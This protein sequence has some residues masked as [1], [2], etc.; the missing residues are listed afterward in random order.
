MLSRLKP[1]QWVNEVSMTEATG[2]AMTPTKISNE[3]AARAMP[4]VLGGERRRLR[5]A[6]FLTVSGAK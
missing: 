3:G 4:T 5:V 6:I 2:T 1:V